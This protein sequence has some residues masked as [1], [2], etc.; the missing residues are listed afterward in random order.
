MTNA[1][2]IVTVDDMPDD[3]T[4]THSI[5]VGGGSIISTINMIADQDYFKVQLVAGTSYEI[6]QYAKLA[7]PNGVPL[8]D[9]YIELYEA[10]GNLVVN[11]DGGGPTTPPGLDALHAFPPE[12]SG[13]YYINGHAIDN[14][15]ANGTTGDIPG[16]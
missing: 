2:L 7:G 16:N 14:A 6:G 12:V 1:G 11:A 5:A 10:S 9:A 3:T 15:H 13:T 4:F 8:A